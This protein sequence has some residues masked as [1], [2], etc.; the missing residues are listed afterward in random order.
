MKRGNPMKVDPAHIGLADHFA[1]KAMQSLI[2]RFQPLHEGNI[3]T[4]CAAAYKI[5]GEM[6]AAREKTFRTRGGMD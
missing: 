4:L 1:A 5:A 6:L 2:A 3:P